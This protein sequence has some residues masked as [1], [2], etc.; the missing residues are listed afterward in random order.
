MIKFYIIYNI[1]IPTDNSRFDDC[2]F[3]ELIDECR[4]NKLKSDEADG[5]DSGELIEWLLENTED[6]SV[7]FEYHLPNIFTNN[8]ITEEEYNS[9]ELGDIVTNHR[10]YVAELDIK[11]F[12]DL[13]NDL[14]PT[15]TCDTMG[16]LT[17]FGLL[18]AFSLETENYNIYENCYVS[19]LFDR[20]LPDTDYIHIENCIRR[21]IEEDNLNEENINDLLDGYRNK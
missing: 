11:Q 9:T 5:L 13:V 8:N 7:N 14:C 2:T 4:Y 19:L 20:Q 10:K 21:M 15:S 18:P 6:D 16:S 1:D 12:I 17:G 3:Y